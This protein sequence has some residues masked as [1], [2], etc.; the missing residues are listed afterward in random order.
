MTQLRID[1]SKKISLFV[2]NN[3]LDYKEVWNIIYEIYY[4]EYG[5]NLHILYKLDMF[6][7]SKL[8]MLEMYEDL[9]HTLTK[10]NNLI[11]EL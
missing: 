3:D 6:G 8:D 9:Y 11:N 2:K 4:K 5:I 10:L 7:K 1:I